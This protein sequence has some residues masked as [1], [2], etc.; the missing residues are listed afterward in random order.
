MLVWVF[1]TGICIL[2]LGSMFLI[3]QESK[4][5]FK[6]DRLQAQRSLKNLQDFVKPEYLPSEEELSEELN[7]SKG[8]PSSAVMDE[9]D[10]NE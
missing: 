5:Q 8:I 1:I 4:R 7:E 10:E 6:K 3:I 9:E 2:A